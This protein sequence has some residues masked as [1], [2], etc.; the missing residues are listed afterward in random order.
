MIAKD[1][2]QSTLVKKVAKQAILTA[3]PLEYLYSTF[4]NIF[5]N[6]IIEIGSKISSESQTALIQLILTERA[7]NLVFLDI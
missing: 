1:H 4:G 5:H 7:L 6:R 3:D 2:Q